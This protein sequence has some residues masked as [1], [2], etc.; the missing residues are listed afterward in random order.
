MQDRHIAKNVRYQKWNLNLNSYPIFLRT[1]LITD[2][3]S[4][5]K[6]SDVCRVNYLVPKFTL[7]FIDYHKKINLQLASGRSTATYQKAHLVLQRA[8]RL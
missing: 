6:T 8:Y 5:F 7:T 3:Y 1:L 4:I 2:S